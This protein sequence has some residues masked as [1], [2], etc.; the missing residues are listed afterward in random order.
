MKKLTILLALFLSGCA[1]F[2]QL[3]RGLNF[4]MDKDES[5]AFEVLGYPTGK[6]ESGS[7]TVYYWSVSRSGTLF[8]PGTSTTSGTVGT[9]PYYG[10][11]TY[12]QAVPVNYNCLIKLVS[13][14]MGYLKHWEFDGNYGGCEHYISRVNQYYQANNP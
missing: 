1:T 3:E 6:Q 13:G 5:V 14:P 7:D 4:M 12:N 8:M 9:T 10:T 11:T 2:G